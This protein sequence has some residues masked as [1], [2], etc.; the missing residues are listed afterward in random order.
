MK[1][2]IF[3]FI[4]SMALMYSC[5]LDI[6]RN[7]NYPSEVGVDK[8]LS[9]GQLW[10]ASAIGGDLQLIGGMWSQHWAQHATANQY[11]N[12]DTYNLLNSDSYVSG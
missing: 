6:N 4:L 1:K 11:N 3:L 2:Y 8:F 10:T 9:S 5:D 7:P 12:I